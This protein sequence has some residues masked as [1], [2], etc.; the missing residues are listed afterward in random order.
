MV[1][2]LWP[3]F[4]GPP[5]I[6]ERVAQQIHEKWKLQRVHCVDGREINSVDRR[7]CGQQARPWTSVVENTIDLPAKFF[8][9]QSFRQSSK[10]SNAR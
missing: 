6:H 10:K 9:V 8:K 1:M 5:C 3:R 7:D 4:L 2:S